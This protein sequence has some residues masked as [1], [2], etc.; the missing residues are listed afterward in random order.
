MCRHNDNTPTYI[1]YFF[2][3]PSHRDFG[4]GEHIP[5]A[6]KSCT[7]SVL[8]ILGDK[9]LC[10]FQPSTQS[11]MMSSCELQSTSNQQ[12][13]MEVGDRLPCVDIEKHPTSQTI[14]PVLS[15]RMCISYSYMLCWQN[16][17]TNVLA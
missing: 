17:H 15:M 9:K 13:I 10:Q 3:H 2:H 11:V 8:Y 16:A 14:N 12:F 1:I 6:S 5:F 4:K 7:Y